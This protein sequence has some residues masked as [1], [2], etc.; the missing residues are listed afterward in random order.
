MEA[1]DVAYVNKSYKYGFNGKSVDNEVSQTGSAYDYGYRIYSTA[2]GRF[3]SKDP[4]SASYP[5]YSPYQFAGNKVIIA[6][7]MDGLEEH[8]TINSPWFTAQVF[9]SM[10]SNKSDSEVE[11]RVVELINCA[12]DAKIPEGTPE[13][14]YN[15]TSDAGTIDPEQNH[16]GIMVKLHIGHGKYITMPL[17]GYQIQNGKVVK[18]TQTEPNDD[19]SEGTRRATRRSFNRFR[20]F[21]NLGFV[22]YGEGGTD[23]S[24]QQKALPGMKLIA[25]Y[26]EDIM[27]LISAAKSGTKQTFNEN[28]KQQDNRRLT[29][30]RNTSNNNSI[31]VKASDKIPEAIN[32]T[33]E[34]AIVNGPDTTIKIPTEAKVTYQ[35]G[36]TFGGEV[37]KTKDTVVYK[38]DVGKVQRKAE[39]DTWDKARKEYN[40]DKN[41]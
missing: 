33:A 21:L 22:L 5:W 24:N 3:F 20:K 41:K 6:V 26:V 25:H 7:D 30:Q 35:T 31:Q 34:K 29:D 18:E 12:L 37:T 1:R 28:M 8:I 40:N 13:S 32:Q 14:V 27:N 9:I 11:V 4:L 17:D 38:K 36:N 19:N 15:G 2:L 10:I 39:K 16:E 23:L